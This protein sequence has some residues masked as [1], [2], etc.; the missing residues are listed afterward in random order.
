MDMFNHSDNMNLNRGDLFRAIQGAMASNLSK[1]INALYVVHPY[2]ILSGIKSNGMLSDTSFLVEI[3]GGNIKVNPGVAIKDAETFIYNSSPQIISVSGKVSGLYYV[4]ARYAQEKTTTGKEVYL[5]TKGNIHPDSQYTVLLDS[6]SIEISTV[7]P[8]ESI[9]LAMVVINSNAVPSPHAAKPLGID[10]PTEGNVKTGGGSLTLPAWASYVTM[11]GN[12]VCRINDEYVMINNLGAITSRSQ[13]GTYPGY[14]YAGTSMVIPS[15]IDLRQLSVIEVRGGVGLERRI[16][17]GVIDASTKSCNIVTRR[18]LQKSPPPTISIG[19]QPIT[20]VNR[21]SSMSMVTEKI[22]MAYYGVQ[23]SAA[24]AS[25]ARAMIQDIRSRMIGATES[26]KAALSIEMRQAQQDLILATGIQQDIMGTL[27]TEELSVYTKRAPEVFSLTVNI[28][29]ISATAVQYEAEVT[30]SLLSS[31]SDSASMRLTERIYSLMK[32]PV[33]FDINGLPVYDTRSDTDISYVSIP[34]KIGER[35]HVRVREI[36]ENGVCGDYSASVAYEFSTY[37]DHEYVSYHN[38]YDIIVPDIMTNVSTMQNYVSYIKEMYESMSS[39]SA[40]LER[41]MEDIAKLS[42]DI[43]KLSRLLPYVDK[44]ISL[45][46]ITP[47][48]TAQSIGLQ[49]NEMDR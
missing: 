2:R 10:V 14:H 21:M 33:G 45:V 6:C 29:D 8:A 35:V 42:G 34:V 17:S 47:D 23:S 7:L 28:G 41:K 9:A 18:V 31:V 19:S 22:K 49:N 1:V 38:I 26:E 36:D 30:R 32:R 24:N 16:K 27:S 44:L 39:M 48:Q 3:V 46:T 11:S 25:N 37:N 43:D 4:Y 12:V 15:I 5:P 20:W 13:Y 40:L